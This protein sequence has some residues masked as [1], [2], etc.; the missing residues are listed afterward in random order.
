MEII[1]VSGLSHPE[2]LVGKMKTT[3]RGTDKKTFP[4]FWYSSL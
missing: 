3:G 2:Q 1:E 4:V